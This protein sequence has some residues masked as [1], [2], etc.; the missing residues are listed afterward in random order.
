[1]LQGLLTTFFLFFHRFHK[2]L[3]SL[4]H[5]L[6]VI[7]GGL[8]ASLRRFAHY[9]YW[10][11]AVRP[12]VLVDAGADLLS[13]GMGENQTIQI[14]RRPVSYTHLIS[15]KT[16]AKKARITPNH[17]EKRKGSGHPS[18]KTASYAPW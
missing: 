5:I 17:P 16:P 12:S 11:D 9:D 18:R 3:L 2:V 8:E 15:T 4:I 6:P 7:I 14:A 10:D 13:Y 1:M